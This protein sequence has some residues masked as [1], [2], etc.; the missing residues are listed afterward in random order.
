MIPAEPSK[1]TPLTR[2]TTAPTVSPPLATEQVRIGILSNRRAGQ[3]DKQLP[4]LRSFLA[5][6]PEV[7]HVETNAAEDVPEVLTDLASQDVGL[8][9]VYGGDGTLQ[10]ILTEILGRRRFG[11]RIPMIAPLRGGST[12]LT[13]LEIGTQRDPIKGIANIIK[14]MEAGRL[15][16]RVCPR[17]VLR[18]RSK[19]G[20]LDE[21][22][23]IFGTGTVYNAVELVQRSFPNGRAQGVFGATVVMGK[24]LFR[25]A[26]H[27]TKTDEE[28]YFREKVQ[29]LLDG[30]PVNQEEF[31]LVISSTLHHIFLNIRPFW[32]QEPAP[33]R[34]TCTAAGAKRFALAIPRLLSGKPGGTVTAEN[35]YTSQNL[36]QVELRMDCGFV[37]DGELIAPE[38]GRILTITAD[39]RLDFVR[40]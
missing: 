20:D 26:L 38:E 13:A 32:G 16:E 9:M 14:V 11:D 30:K 25:R 24:M 15:G 27:K 3:S 4:R 35:G 36:H 17:H 21:Y 19:R 12:N 10:H 18:L 1:R 5:A 29:I 37:V 8:L 39:D 23:M 40:V 7:M 34:F 28:K 33:V 2:K 22:G 6:H 31:L